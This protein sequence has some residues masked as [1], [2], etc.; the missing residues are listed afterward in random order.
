MNKS[1]MTKELDK[2]PESLEIESDLPEHEYDDSALV[3]AVANYHE[4]LAVFNF[5]EQL[6]HLCRGIQRHRGLSIGL[7]AGTR[8]FF[9][10]FKQLQQQ[11]L[12]RIRLIESF[13]RHMDGVL[14]DADIEKIR[15]AWHTVYDNWQ[16]DSVL[17]N[18]EYHSYFAEQLLLMVVR[19]SEKIQTPYI[20]SIHQELGDESQPAS[21][22]D[23]R[24]SYMELL[25][26]SGRRLPPFIELLGKA[27]ALSVHC[28]AIGRAEKH[29][30]QKLSYIVQCIGGE[31][32]KIF[33]LT[34][35]MQQTLGNSLPSMLTVKIHEYKLGLLLDKINNEILD[36]DKITLNTED[37]FTLASDV[38]DAYWGAV[39]DSLNLLQFWHHQ[40]LEQWLV[41]G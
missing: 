38:I 13:A 36:V 32:D 10:G 17:E 24:S 3:G 6:N 11:M 20:Q 9:D 26:F 1:T 4:R 25:H 22:A 27:R 40:D 23:F 39:D 19:L 8:T 18:F 35:H 34:S 41:E 12:R 2:T 30:G 7:L 21:P 14:S 5:I 29:I 31:R 28:V 37:I 15:S 33:H 16:D